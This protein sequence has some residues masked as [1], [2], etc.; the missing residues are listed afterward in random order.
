M[1][2][3]KTKYLDLL[4]KTL[5]DDFI[6]NRVVPFLGAGF[7]KNADSINGDKICDWNELGKQIASYIPGYEYKNPLDAL[8]LFE[9]KYTRI[10]LIETIEKILDLQSKKPSSTLL[11]FCN[12]PF[13]IICTTNYD[14][15][16]EDSFRI[17]KMPYSLVVTEE[18]LP[19]NY[20][21]CT[22]I[23]K[24]HGDFNN[25]R[26]LIITEDDYDNFLE[27]HKLLCTYISNL[28]INHTILLIGYS[29]DDNDVRQLWKIIR[30]RL[31]KMTTPGY[32]LLVDASDF[33]I[34]RFKYRGFNV[35]NLPGD[36]EN[37]KTILRDL[38]DEIKLE[39][40]NK[41]YEYTIYSDNEY[42]NASK[43]PSKYNNMCLLVCEEKDVSNLK[44]YL[45]DL[46]V[47]NNIVLTTVYDIVMPNNTILSKIRIMS[48]KCSFC[49][50]NV[51]SSNIRILRE[52]YSS[53]VKKFIYIS[54]IKNK[55]FIPNEI[56]N[57]VIFYD[58][59]LNNNKNFI[60]ELQTKIKKILPK[61]NDDFL[62]KL[63]NNN[64]YSAAVLL[65][66]RELEIALNDIPTNGYSISYKM[67]SLTGTDDESIIE[68]KNV[69][70]Y[71]SIRNKIAHSVY[72]V[73]EEEAREIVRSVKNVIEM[74][75]NKRI[76]IKNIK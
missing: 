70:M 37:Y 39:I 49:I 21:D 23:I 74:I 40:E 10:K 33:E 75:N 61:K 45:G 36:R 60:R 57:S 50:F 64:E 69:L 28:F 1:S 62:E 16:I 51:D 5:L 25:P 73:S 41:N 72:S 65:V 63:I 18:S 71:I 46:L 53:D 13:N 26:E 32:V 58:L 38:F 22:K 66:F 9:S 59:S 54:N 47:Q 34:E 29:F 6:Y 30:N 20:N 4:P 14:T 44:E 19:I 55:D 42:S 35:I 3:K 76:V 24:L 15:F 27:K 68:L 43:I 7:S 67:R 2:D 52:F 31:G 8:S 17:N 56:S 48:D 12:I 11:S